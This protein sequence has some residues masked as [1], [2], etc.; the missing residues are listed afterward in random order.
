MAL[1]GEEEVGKVCRMVNMVQ[2]VCIHVYKW[3][4][5]TC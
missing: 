3:K 2:I 4:D 5:D 1:V